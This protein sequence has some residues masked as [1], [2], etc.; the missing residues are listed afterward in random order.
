MALTRMCAIVHSSPI[1]RRFEHRRDTMASKSLLLQ[2]SSRLEL[3]L[4][5]ELGR[6]PL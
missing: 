3:K 1:K 2:Q 5:L 4:E 6:L